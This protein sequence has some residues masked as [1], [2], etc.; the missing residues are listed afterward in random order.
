[1]KKL[2]GNYMKITGEITTGN[3]GVVIT[4]GNARHKF[5]KGRSFCGQAGY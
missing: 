3:Y 1:M 4:V 2:Y 5:K